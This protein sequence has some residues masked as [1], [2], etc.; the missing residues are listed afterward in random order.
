MSTISG[1]AV[2]VITD[3]SWHNQWHTKTAFV[4]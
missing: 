1:I 4:T 3:T 2:C